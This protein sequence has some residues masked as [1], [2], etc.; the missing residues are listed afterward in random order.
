MQLTFTPIHKEDLEDVISMFQA[1]ADKISRMNIDHW[2]YWKN[3]PLEKINWVKE[4]IE[5]KEY[6]FVQNA[7]EEVLGMVRIL[8]ED[9]LYWGK[10]DEK[11]RYIH[12][13]LVKEEYNGKGLGIQILNTIAEEAKAQDCKYLRLDADSTNP[14]LCRYYEKQGFQKVGIK[15][16]PI[17][18][19]NLYEKA[20]A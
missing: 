14:K 5:N 17:S 7:D 19:Y 13:L 12:S 16:L 4:G 15:K 20:L 2:Q 18:T 11:A 1:A 6:F 3:P 10:Q 8:D 9:L